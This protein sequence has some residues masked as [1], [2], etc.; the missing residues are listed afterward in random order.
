MKNVLLVLALLSSQVCLANGSTYP[1]QTEGSLVSGVERGIPGFSGSYQ[2][3]RMCAT[4]ALR[5]SFEGAEQMFFNP[6][7]PHCNALHFSAGMNAMV[8]NVP[9]MLYITNMAIMTGCYN[10]LQ[11]SQSYFTHY[12][13]CVVQGGR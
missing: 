11:M 9:G 1:N 5:S 12:S 2:K 4:Q 3:N 6:M 8:G 13:S 7:I 10:P